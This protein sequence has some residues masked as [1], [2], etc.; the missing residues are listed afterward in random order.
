[1]EIV[2]NEIR[3]RLRKELEIYPWLD[4]VRQAVLEDMAYNLGVNGLLKFRTMLTAL[5]KWDYAG[6]V[7]GMKKSKWWTQVGPRSK[8]LAKM[9]LTGEWPEEMV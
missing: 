9:M 3:P 7:A 1:M 8:R 4:P 5:G 2:E 6:A